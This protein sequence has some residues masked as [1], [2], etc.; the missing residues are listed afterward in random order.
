MEW[1]LSV[2]SGRSNGFVVASRLIPVHPALAAVVL[3]LVEC[4]LSEWTVL[5]LDRL[6]VAREAEVGGSNGV[7]SFEEEEWG[8]VLEGVG[9]RGS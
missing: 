9:L 5:A 8:C 2:V 3:T 6:V 4:P 1:T 7:D